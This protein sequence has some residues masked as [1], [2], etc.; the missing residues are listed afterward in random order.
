MNE[1]DSLLDFRTRV[2][3]FGTREIMWTP[4]TRVKLRTGIKTGTP[5]PIPIISMVLK[6]K[7]PQG[8][9]AEGMSLTAVRRIP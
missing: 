5:W 9:V 6:P 8:D 2:F 1:S 7:S 3:C 4:R